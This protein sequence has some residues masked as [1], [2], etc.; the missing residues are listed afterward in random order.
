MAS[1]IIQN[2]PVALIKFKRAER[3]NREALSENKIKA[4]LRHIEDAKYNE[5]RQGAYVL[6]YFGLRPCEIDEET[7]IEDDFLI[8]RNR[9]RKNGKIEYKKFPIP[10]EALKKID[11]NKPLVFQCGKERFHNLFK[12]LLDGKTAFTSHLRNHLSAIRSSRYC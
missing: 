4:F 11:W 9:K 5:I 1:G 8:T 3:Q 10:K 7:H 2:N 6:Y 12:E